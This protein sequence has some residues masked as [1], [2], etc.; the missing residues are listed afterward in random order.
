MIAQ[1]NFLNLTLTRSK[2]ILDGITLYESVD[3]SIL[4]KLIN[5]L[6]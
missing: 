5:S 1:E 4:D 2:N 3:V 6:F